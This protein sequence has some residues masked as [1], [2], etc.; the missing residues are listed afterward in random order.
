MNSMISMISISSMISIISMI[1]MVHFPALTKNWY[2]IRKEKQDLMVSSDRYID[3][4]SIY[5]FI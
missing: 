2:I 5:P 3:I 1:S 4:E